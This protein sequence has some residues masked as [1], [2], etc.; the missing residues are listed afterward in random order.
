M[1]P[2]KQPGTR[3][4]CFCFH[5]SPALLNR[6]GQASLRSSLSVQFAIRG[7]LLLFYFL[8]FL[9]E[10]LF[11]TRL[12]QSKELCVKGNLQKASSVGDRRAGETMQGDAASGRD[13][14]APGCCVGKWVCAIVEL[15]RQLLQA[16]LLQREVHRQRAGREHDE[17]HSARAGAPVETELCLVCCLGMGFRRGQASRGAQP[18][19]GP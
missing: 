19:Q 2:C 11:F 18:A 10:E 9:C 17:T 16:G 6:R 12:G 1:R 14:S 4:S 5:G 7:I 13:S 3:A 15:V 8:F